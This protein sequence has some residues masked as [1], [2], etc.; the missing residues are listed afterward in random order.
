MRPSLY[1]VKAILIISNDGKRII[2]KYY[3]DHLKSVKEQKDFEKSLFQKTHK[4][5]SEIVM[6]D[7]VTV[8]YR[9]C[10][11]LFF[12]VIGSLSEN[13]IMLMNLLNCL[14]DTINLALRKNVEKR[15]L[16]DNLDM[17]FLI[18]DELCDQGIIT[19]TDPNSIAR[20]VLVKNDDH[21]PLSEQTVVDVLRAILK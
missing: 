6:L 7:G 3:D 20:R 12:Y 14:Y 1:T 13:E 5:N 2:G 4:A 10:V 9:S 8:V 15:T 11:D 17:I 16:Y 18:I 21:I 19:D